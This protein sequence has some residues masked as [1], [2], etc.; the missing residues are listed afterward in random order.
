[1]AKH[2]NGGKTNGEATGDGTVR[3][4]GIRTRNLRGEEARL[5]AYRRRRAYHRPQDQVFDGSQEVEEGRRG[6][7]IGTARSWVN[8]VPT[9][10]SPVPS[11]TGAEEVAKQ[12]AR[13]IMGPDFSKFKKKGLKFDLRVRYPSK[14]TVVRTIE[15]SYERMDYLILFELGKDGN[16]GR[17]VCS[18]LDV[19][20]FYPEWDRIATIYLWL[21]NLQRDGVT[22]SRFNRMFNILI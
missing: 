19:Q 16:M 1:M 14:R 13:R 8:E 9:P 5:S 10:A 21:T 11:T 3:A 22:I 18:Q 17:L 4:S 2:P 7:V 12:L 15:M 20:E 6:P